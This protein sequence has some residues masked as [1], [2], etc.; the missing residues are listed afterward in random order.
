MK[1]HKKVDEIFFSPVTEDLQ[2][3]VLSVWFFLI[4]N[5]YFKYIIMM[6][7]CQ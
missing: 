6:Y 1:W 5:I 2:I 4:V 7:F 3:E